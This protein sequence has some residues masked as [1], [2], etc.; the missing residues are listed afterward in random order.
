MVL[1]LS[2]LGLCTSLF[3]FVLVFNVIICFNVVE[4]DNAIAAEE[5]GDLFKSFVLRFG[6]FTV[7]KSPKECEQGAERKEYIVSQRDL[8]I[9]K[10]RKIVIKL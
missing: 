9:K 5:S 1:A 6:D 4:P 8:E 2:W 10:W 7:R 3:V